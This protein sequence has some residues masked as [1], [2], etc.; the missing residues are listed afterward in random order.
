MASPGLPK[1]S[2]DLSTDL[3]RVWAAIT[4]YEAG[5]EMKGFRHGAVYDSTHCLLLIH[6]SPCTVHARLG[7]PGWECHAG[8][9]FPPSTTCLIGSP[10]TRSSEWPH[11][12]PT[13]QD[14]EAEA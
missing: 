14:E 12:H 13:I 9:A 10:V 7:M 4:G 8:N 5:L 11:S 3:E 2:R 1:D 6:G